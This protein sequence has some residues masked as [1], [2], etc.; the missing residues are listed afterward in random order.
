MTGLRIAGACVDRAG[1]RVVHDVDLEVAAGEVTILL[2]ANGVGK[3]TLLDGVAGVTP[4]QSGQIHLDG[5]DIGRRS[6]P[7]RVRAG[8]AYVQQGREVFGDLTVEENLLVAAPRRRIGAAFEL[9]PELQQRAEVAA[10]LLS[11]GEQQMLVLARALLGKPKVLMID[12]LSLG[13]APVIVDRVLATVAELATGGM[14]VLLVEQ[15]ADRALSFGHR[16]AVMSRGRIVLR[17]P[18]AEL[19]RHPERL[20]AAYLGGETDRP[21]LPDGDP[22]T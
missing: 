8:L 21:D 20:Q 18:A 16:A 15:F 7:G 6:R 17:G 3:S 13:L 2:G 10:S 14:G 4:M 1:S 19:R 12:E 11:G 5:A 9:F 22:E